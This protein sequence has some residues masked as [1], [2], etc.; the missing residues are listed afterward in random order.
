MPTRFGAHVPE[1]LRVFELAIAT[2][3]TFRGLNTALCGEIDKQRA[4]L[5]HLIEDLE[6]LT[7]LAE[8]PGMI[9]I[10][11]CNVYMHC[12]MFSEV[13][14]RQELG[15]DVVRIVLQV[16]VI[17]ELDKIK[18]FERGNRQD[19]ARMVVKVLD[20]FLPALEADGIATLRTKT[21]LE[22]LVDESGHQRLADVDNEIIERGVLLKQAT[23]RPVPMV[24]DDRGMRVQAHARGLSVWPVPEHLLL[25]SARLA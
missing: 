1:R 6:R 8:H 15:H 12:T 19:R 23:G 21:T 24:S 20:Q 2:T 4:C 3:S 25:P 5:T 11:D 10:L 7:K 13:D 16:A 18:Y 22:I 14:W 9:T 17:R